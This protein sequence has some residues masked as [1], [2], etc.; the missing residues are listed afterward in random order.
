MAPGDADDGDTRVD[1]PR[2]SVLGVR[3]FHHESVAVAALGQREVGD[4]NG[5]VHLLVGRIAAEDESGQPAERHV[6]ARVE[7]ALDG[8]LGDQVGLV[9]SDLVSIT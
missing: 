7:A 3:P 9:V 4:R 5:H 1:G 6:A 8:G 2:K